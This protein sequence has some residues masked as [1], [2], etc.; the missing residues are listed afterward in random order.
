MYY[1]LGLW[2]W[3]VLLVLYLKSDLLS[4]LDSYVL[5]IMEVYIMLRLDLV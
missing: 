4:L 3:L 2:L 5:K 1:L